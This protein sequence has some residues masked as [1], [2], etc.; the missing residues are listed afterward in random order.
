MTI[1]ELL[2][3]VWDYIDSIKNIERAKYWFWLPRYKTW[4]E[5]LLKEKWSPSLPK[6]E[7]VL[8][9]VNDRN[10]L[11]CPGAPADAENFM[12]FLVRLKDTKRK[13]IEVLVEGFECK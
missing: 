3:N 12:E 11:F 7:S 9:K 10:P 2:Q 5:E 13:K 8:K 1:T 6:L 4:C